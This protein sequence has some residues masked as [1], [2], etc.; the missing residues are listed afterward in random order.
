MKFVN[1]SKLRRLSGKAREDYLCIA[2]SRKERK[3]KAALA[4]MGN[5]CAD[6][7][8]DAMNKPGVMR[9]FLEGPK[10]PKHKNMTV[11][12]FG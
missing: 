8:R 3:R 6:L 11:H 7:L 12:K 4:T 9:L 1:K 2:A 10:P 5:A